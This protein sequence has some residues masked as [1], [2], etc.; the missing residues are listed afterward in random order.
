M[1]FLSN[2]TRTMEGEHSWSL[3]GAGT[4]SPEKLRDWPH[5]A[6]SEHELAKHDRAML[7]KKQSMPE[8]E[9]SKMNFS[10]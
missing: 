10:Y 6:A 5:T 7:S 4:I 3:K 9:Q 2:P 8:K 1:L